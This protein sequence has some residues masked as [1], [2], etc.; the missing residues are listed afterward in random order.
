MQ[1]IYGYKEEDVL[2]L[3]QFI[4]KGNYKTLSQ[5]FENY[6]TE[7]GKAKGT[8]RNL[9]YALAR[10]SRE[11]AEFRKKYLNDKTLEVNSIV[12]FDKQE[13]KELVD[14]VNKLTSEGC[15]VRS[16]ILQLS[17]GDQ[18]LGLRYQNK[19]RNVVK[20]DATLKL[21]AVKQVGKDV[22]SNISNLQI[23]RLKSEINGLVER[24]AQGVRKENQKLRS[25]IVLL[26]KENLRLKNQAL[27]NNQAVDIKQFFIKK[28]NSNKH[29]SV[30]KQVVYNLSFAYLDIWLCLSYNLYELKR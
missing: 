10:K 6:A 24:L 7:S 14:N 5:A 2:G 26:E 9:Y 15:S 1:K 30:W 18:K 25:R 20:K 22:L 8:I 19:Y 29:F 27:I 21:R 16:A 28:D 11:D 13:E 12:C 17:Q 23:K 3:I 4:N